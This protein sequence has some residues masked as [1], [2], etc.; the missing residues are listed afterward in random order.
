MI[1]CAKTGLVAFAALLFL[2]GSVRAQI[3]PFHGTLEYSAATSTWPKLVVK[4]ANGSVGYVL[5]LKPEIDIHDDLV[6]INLILQPSHAKPEAAN[7]LEPEYTWHG[8]QEYMFNASD[9]LEGPEHSVF[10]RVRHVAIKRC[11][12]DV[13]FSVVKV[14]IKPERDGYVFDEL[15]IGVSVENA[16]WSEGIRP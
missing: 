16:S 14:K 12:L 4:A 11:K 2:V 1:R 9:F 15:A 5:T 10:G 13:T 7:L 3:A 6:G 8:L